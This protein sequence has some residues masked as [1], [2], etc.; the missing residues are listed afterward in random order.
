VPA[1]SLKVIGR[2]EH[3]VFGSLAKAYAEQSATVVTSNE[4]KAP[5]GL[6]GMPPPGAAPPAAKPPSMMTPEQA[7]P[8][9][10]WVYVE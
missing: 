3:R 7:A 4:A 2:G 8:R 10:T 6:A 9:W 1:S 5:A